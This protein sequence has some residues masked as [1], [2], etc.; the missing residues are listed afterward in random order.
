M[1]DAEN[2]GRTD[3]IQMTRTS[4][5]N[6][7]GG[8]GRPINLRGQ[9]GRG[10]GGHRAAQAQRLPEPIP[11]HVPSLD[12][13]VT[14]SADAYQAEASLYGGNS[15]LTVRLVSYDSDTSSQS[16]DSSSTEASESSNTS[17]VL[18]A[19]EAPVKAVEQLRRA[20]ASL[21][22]TPSVGGSVSGPPSKVCKFFARNGRCRL[23][24]K[25]R[26]AHAAPAR[27]ETKSSAAAS[28]STDRPKNDRPHGDRVNP[29]AR[30]SILGAVSDT[31][32]SNADTSC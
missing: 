14:P 12:S 31:T 2:W 29:F 7:G 8:R 27:E 23:G 30:P 5:D 10:R 9:R 17:S 19:A 1:K 18:T 20:D 32:W 6:F 26:F 4:R 15:S 16:T 25:C 28:L 24:S 21:G 22:I 13:G 11:H 3:P